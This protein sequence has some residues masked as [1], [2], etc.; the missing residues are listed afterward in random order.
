VLATW[1]GMP[2]QVEVAGFAFPATQG[3][4][5]DKAIYALALAVACRPR[6]LRKLTYCELPLTLVSPRVLADEN[7]TLVEEDLLRPLPGRWDVI[8]VANV[9]NRDYFSE[10]ILRQ[11][12]DNLVASLALDGVLAVCRTDPVLGNRASLLRRARTGLWLLAELNGG[13]EVAGLIPHKTADESP[14]SSR[15]T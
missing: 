3:R 5:R 9:V 8:R 15:S 12:L 11:L 6:L 4:R 10:P 13:S 1:D 14:A 7:L 2:L